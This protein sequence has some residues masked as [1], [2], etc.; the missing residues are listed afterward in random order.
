[1]NH[2]CLPLLTTD[3]AAAMLN[4]HSST[5]EKGRQSYRKDLFPPFIRIGRAVRYRRADIEKWLDDRLVHV[6]EPLA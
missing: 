6:G 1:M 2:E 4:V 3:Q 5:L